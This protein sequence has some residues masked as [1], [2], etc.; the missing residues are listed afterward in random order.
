MRRRNANK[1]A[2][3]KARV[4]RFHGLVAG[5]GVEMHQRSLSVPRRLYSLFS[6]IMILSRN[7]G[8]FMRF[9]PD[10]WKSTCES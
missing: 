8:V 5:S 3:V 1:E 4:V 2:P 7:G 10:L 6:D 9:S